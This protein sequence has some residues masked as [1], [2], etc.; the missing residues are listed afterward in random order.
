MCGICGV[1]DC[2]G[3]LIDGELVARMAGALQHRGPDGSGLYISRE[4]GLGHRRL[5]IID[6]DGG[7]Q[8]ITNEDSTL[9]LVF[10]GEI[11]NFIELREELLAHGHVFKTRSDTEVIIHSYEQWGPDCVSRFNGMFAIALWDSIRKQLFLARDH[12]GVKPL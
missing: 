6:L 1:L 7:A 4:I 12:L 9:H 2:N 8:P 11:Y 3:E 5:S 10:N